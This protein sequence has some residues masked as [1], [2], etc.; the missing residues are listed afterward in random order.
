MASL[1]SYLEDVTKA[2]RDL[3][4]VAEVIDSFRSGL[5]TYPCKGLNLV[6]LATTLAVD[7]DHEGHD[8]RL[9]ET[10]VA[11]DERRIVKLLFADYQEKQRT[12]I[13]MLRLRLAESEADMAGEDA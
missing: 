9:W 7:A 5:R 1:L 12:L 3:L 11:Q 13:D 10:F 8:V 2:A 6:S 4:E